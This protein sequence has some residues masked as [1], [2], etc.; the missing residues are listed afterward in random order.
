MKRQVYDSKYTSW[1]ACLCVQCVHLCMGALVFGQTCLSVTVHVWMCGGVRGQHQGSSLTTLLPVLH[2]EAGSLSWE[3]SIP[4]QTVS[5]ISLSCDPHPPCALSAPCALSTPCTLRIG[6]G[7]S[8][9]SLLHECCRSKFIP[10]SHDSL[11][12]VHDETFKLLKFDPWFFIHGTYF[13]YEACLADAFP[14]ITSLNVRAPPLYYTSEKLFSWPE[15]DN[16]FISQRNWRNVS[17]F[18]QC[19]NGSWVLCNYELAWQAISIRNPWHW[20]S[21]DFTG[22]L[23][24]LRNLK[25]TQRASVRTLD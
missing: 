23:G 14:N 4:M 21:G 2:V 10:V 24:S 22:T 1:F 20:P 7:S 11:P 9:S 17:G 3:Q 5:L 12:L 25:G 18:A 15:T 8:P 16:S 19:V 13:Y 6:V